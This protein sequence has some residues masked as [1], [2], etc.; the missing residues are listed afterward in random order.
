MTMITRANTFEGEIEYRE[1][2]KVEA[3]NQ[4]RYKSDIVT[5]YFIPWETEERVC[6][7]HLKRDWSQQHEVTPPSAPT[8][9]GPICGCLLTQAGLSPIWNFAQH[10]LFPLLGSH[11]TQ[12]EVVWKIFLQR[13]GLCPLFLEKEKL[14][15]KGEGGN[16]NQ[17]PFNLE[18]NR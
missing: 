15:D 12:R 9:S 18:G 14:L 1:Q 6:S 8:L 3:R 4:H 2:L 13:K 7:N 5:I 10:E 11:C 16:Q 17:S